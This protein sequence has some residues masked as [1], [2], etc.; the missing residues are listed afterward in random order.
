MA[1]IYIRTIS[2]RKDKSS[3]A[4]RQKVPLL[5]LI[6]AR[7]R[8]SDAYV[9][10]KPWPDDQNIKYYLLIDYHLLLKQGFPLIMSQKLKEK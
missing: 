4:A 8:E 2:V 10:L 7:L 6:F 9:D 1:W 5:P 3:V